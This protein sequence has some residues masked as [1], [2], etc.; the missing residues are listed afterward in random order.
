MVSNKWAIHGVWFIRNMENGLSHIVHL[1]R[2]RSNT[3]LM[4]S[5]NNGISQ[6]LWARWQHLWIFI[7][8]SPQK[9]STLSDIL[10]VHLIFCFSPW[11]SDAEVVEPPKDDPCKEVCIFGRRTGLYIQGAPRRCAQPWSGAGRRLYLL[12]RSRFHNSRVEH[13]QSQHW[14]LW[15]IR[16]FGACHYSLRYSDSNKLCW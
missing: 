1:P 5:I 15:R 16:P 3:A 12:W 10:Y 6:T 13:A 2:I 8:G 14:S 4:S 7:Y 9:V 11:L